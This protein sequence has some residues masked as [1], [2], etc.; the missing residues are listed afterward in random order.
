[1]P[2]ELPNTYANVTG[3]VNGTAASQIA[4]LGVA[5]LA[6]LPNSANG[7]AGASPDFDAIRPELE[8]ILRAE[9]TALFA[10]IAAAP[11]A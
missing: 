1:M 2:T 6:L 5:L 3:V 11:T 4:A 8:V 9:I 7:T 10:A